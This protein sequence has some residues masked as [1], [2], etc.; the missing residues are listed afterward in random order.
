MGAWTGC[1]R[2]CAQATEAWATEGGAWLITLCRHH[3]REHE[4]ALHV[5]GFRLIEVFVTE[6]ELAGQ[7]G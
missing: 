5:K 7:P 2:C 1:D 4:V 3:A 6:R